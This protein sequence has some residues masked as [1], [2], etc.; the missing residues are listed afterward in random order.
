MSVDEFKTNMYSKADRKLMSFPSFPVGS[1]IE[2]TVVLR[3]SGGAKYNQPA[4]LFV[5]D[6]SRKHWNTY[7]LKIVQQWH[8]GTEKMY[9]GCD[10]IQC[11]GEKPHGDLQHL[12]LERTAGD[13]MAMQL[14]YGRST[15]PK[16]VICEYTIPEEFVAD[17][18]LPFSFVSQDGALILHMDHSI[19]R[20]IEIEK[21]AKRSAYF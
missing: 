4:I 21:E 12:R 1:H 10:F 13:K 3:A 20:L 17:L 7:F 18:D 2:L 15:G 6:T 5:P 16:G 11:G 14:F 19:P 9:I 8:E